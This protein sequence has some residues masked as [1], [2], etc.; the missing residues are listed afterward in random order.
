MSDMPGEDEVITEVGTITPM[1]LPESVALDRASIDMQVATARAFPRSV[2]KALL[3]AEGLA[4]LDEETAGSMFYSLPKRK[5]QDKPVEG[6]SARL[7]EIMAYSWGNLRVEADIVGEDKTHITALGTCF[8]LERNVAVRI[9]VKRRITNKHGQRF[10]DDMIGVTGN[11]AVSI[12]LRNA[13]FKVIPA[14]L[15]RRV[16][17]AARQASIGKAGTLDQKRQAAMEWFSKAGIK[18]EQIYQLLDV[19]GWD[20]VGIEHII[21]LRGTANAIKEGETTL[22]QV[23]NPPKNTDGAQA[24]DAALAGQNPP[25]PPEPK[26]EPEPAQPTPERP[27]T[28]DEERQMVTEAYRKASEKAA[29]LAEAGKLDMLE[30]GALDDARDRGELGVLIKMDQDFA[31]R[32]KA[33]P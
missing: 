26:K 31:K 28:S 10:G 12:A 21:M 30:S 32:L 3:E 20:D 8:D 27:E 5:G 2:T 29:K 19:K 6:P 7:A 15:V 17:S 9:R 33:K 4:T 14:A 18:P 11:A 23:F 22:E 25:P 13:V 16:Y 1:V 24:L